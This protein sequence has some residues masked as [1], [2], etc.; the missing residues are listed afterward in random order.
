MN[1]DKDVIQHRS[2]H[3]MLCGVT[4]RRTCPLHDS[5]GM[6]AFSFLKEPAPIPGILY[7][8]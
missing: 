2:V 1:G 7:M 4:D 6:N 3:C 5:E 8:H